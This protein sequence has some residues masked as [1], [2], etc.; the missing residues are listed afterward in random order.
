MRGEF[1]FTER[2]VEMKKTKLLPCP[3]CGSDD[4]YLDF[5]V[6]R[7]VTF[8]IKA[9]EEPE[10]TYNENRLWYI[11]CKNCNMATDGYGQPE[12]I[13]EKWNNRAAPSLIKET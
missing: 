2:I 13:V 11:T 10:A 12:F 5:N 9:N 6:E 4:V 8:E 1:T 3:F 7:G